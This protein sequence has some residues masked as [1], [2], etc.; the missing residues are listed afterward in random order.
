VR[1]IGL[2]GEELAAF[3]NTLKN[4]DP[5]QFKA[6][7]KSL[8]MVIPSMS[9]IEV[10]INNV[11]E[12]EL[13]VREGS[14]PIPARVLSE[15][16]LRILGLLALGGPKDPPA[17][18]GLEEPKNGIHPRRIQIIAEYLKGRA[19]E[20]ETQIIVTTHSPILPDLIPDRSLFVCGKHDG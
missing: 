3:L 1:H 11:G 17:L 16:T 12:V 9:G 8:R 7:E 13:R 4:L 18:I 2:M 20:A 10:D 15:G 6:V 5:A 19:L 14:T